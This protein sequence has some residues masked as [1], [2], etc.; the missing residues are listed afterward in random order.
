MFEFENSITIH[1]SIEDV[2][3]FVT[4]L[5]TVPKWNYY[6]R[7]V[8]PTSD[9]PG[10]EG[11]TY[12]QIRKNDEQELVIASLEPNRSL[13]VES[14]PPSKPEFRREMTFAGD[15]ESTT[16]TDRWQLDLGVPRLLEGLAA[17][18]ARS[19]VQENLGKLK[20]LLETGRVTLQDGRHFTL[21]GVV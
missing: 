9:H 12:H 3:R 6:V 14:I 15:G 21:Q 7:S 11:A 20:V 18:R 2:F 8:T 1:R 4:D 17:R 13:V 16:I 10:T 5:T 19:G